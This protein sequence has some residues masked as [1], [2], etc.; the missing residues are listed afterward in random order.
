[1]GLDIVDSSHP[2]VA[3]F[4]VPD[5]GELDIEGIDDSEIDSYLMNETEAQRKDQLWHNLNAAYLQEKK[6]KHYV[7]LSCSLLFILYIFIY[8]S[9]DTCNL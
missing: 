9:I 4:V 8:I 6:G 1:M 7:V 5:N 3:K 2:S